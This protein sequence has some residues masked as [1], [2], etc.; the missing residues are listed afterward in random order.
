MTTTSLRTGAA[1]LLALAALAGAAGT[2]AAATSSFSFSGSTDSG[3]LA[4][5]AFSGS[6]AFDD[7]M[8]TAGFSGSIDLVSFSLG[9]AGQTY[10]L[11]S[12]D[13]TPTAFFEAGQFIGIDYV[14]VDS[15]DTALRPAVALVPSLTGQLADAYLSYEGA[16]ELVGFGSYSV[17]A[18]PEPGQWALLL[19][20]GLGLAAT[21]RR[22]AAHKV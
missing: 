3:P 14:D 18:V 4:G 22:R 5:Q 6:F 17:S 9:L 10:T 16:G 11:A 21:L 7:A 1:R 12:A 2:T 20:G 8:L 13:A 19:A 15:P